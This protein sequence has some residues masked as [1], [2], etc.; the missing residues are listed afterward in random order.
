MHLQLS[1]LRLSRDVQQTADLRDFL[2][3]SPALVAV[4]L[5]PLPFPA[6]NFGGAA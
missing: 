5:V 1:F 3:V 4:L 2:V 6:S